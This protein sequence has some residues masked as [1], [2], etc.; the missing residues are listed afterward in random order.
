[1]RRLWGDGPIVLKGIQSVSDAAQAVQAGMDGIWVSN[2]GGRQVDGAVPSLRQLPAI[3]QYIR[4]LPAKDGKER[5]SIIFDSGVR[6]G[7]DIMKALCLSADAIAI[8][9]PWAWGLAANGQ[10]GVSDV[11]KMLLAD[12]EL[13]CALAGY[14]SS[15][16][17]SPTALV[18]ADGKL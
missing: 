13:N 12:F 18:K 2:H 10:K 16:Q 9:R 5:P 17:L 8:G 11:L 7:A 15:S 14:Q 3:A 1:L 6:S 4:A